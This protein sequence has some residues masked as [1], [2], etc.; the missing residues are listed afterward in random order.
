[1]C[2]SLVSHATLI[3]YYHASMLTLQNSVMLRALWLPTCV[4]IWSLE[5]ILDIRGANYKECDFTVV[6][7]GANKHKFKFL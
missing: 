5:C 3:Q 4:I 2:Y 1:L 6:A 7:L